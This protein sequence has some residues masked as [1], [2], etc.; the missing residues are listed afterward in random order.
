MDCAVR[1][2]ELLFKPN[3][4]TY[5]RVQATVNTWPQWKKEAFNRN[6][7]FRNKQKSDK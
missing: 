2:Q 3:D 7:S 4:E 6:F 1:E 5:E